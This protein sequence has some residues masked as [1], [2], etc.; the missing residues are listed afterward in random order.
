VPTRAHGELATVRFALADDVGDLVEVVG[1]TSRS[2][3]TARSTGES[4]S[5]TSRNAID[6]ESASSACRAGS[7][8]FASVSNG[9]G[10]HSPT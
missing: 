8:A 6:S 9:S 5:N 1:K 4:R 3:N 7:G 10:S 2:R